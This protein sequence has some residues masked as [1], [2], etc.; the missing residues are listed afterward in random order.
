VST[1]YT[2]LTRNEA[3]I[4][5]HAIIPWA[6]QQ[7]TVTYGHL[8]DQYR[9]SLDVER[10]DPRELN[11]KIVVLNIVLLELAK[12]T[13]DVTMPPISAIIINSKTR[14]AHED[15]KPFILDYLKISNVPGADL[16]ERAGLAWG[17]TA[18]RW[19]LRV[20]ERAV[21]DY[22][23]WENL[24]AMIIAMDEKEFQTLRTDRQ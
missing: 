24:K 4:L 17:A 14:E 8:H 16:P 6:L 18:W 19:A 12:R 21:W 10:V 7:R 23:G 13:G 3:L 22:K 1:R 11:K 20:V 9:M 15:S 2:E 5:L